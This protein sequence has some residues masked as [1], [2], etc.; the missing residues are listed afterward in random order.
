MGSL[1]IVTIE[2]HFLT[3]NVSLGDK[4]TNPVFWSILLL[5]NKIKKTNAYTAKPFTKVK[6]K[7]ALTVNQAGE[8]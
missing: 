4:T 2:R 3:L 7:I 1:W 5:A 8:S 6:W